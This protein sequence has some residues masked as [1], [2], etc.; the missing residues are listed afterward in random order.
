MAGSRSRGKRKKQG[1]GAAGFLLVLFLL[2][3]VAAG[4]AGWAIFT[5]FGPSTETFVDIPT[6]SSTTHIARQLQASGIIR[7]QF[8]FDLW[9]W[10]R[11]GKLK[12]GEYRF[13]HP[14]PLTE[15]YG[16][17]ARGEVYT[18]AVTVPEGAT[19]FDVANRL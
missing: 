3:L 12:A 15:V 2:A 1:L 4:V 17:I 7:S 11:R 5:P 9:R 6:G 8:A 10:V 18:V 13:D 16:R 14:M 19:V